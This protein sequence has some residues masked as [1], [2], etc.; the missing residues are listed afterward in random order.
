MK[1]PFVIAEGI[2]GSGKGMI[3]GALKEWAFTKKLKVFDLRGYWKDNDSIPEYEEIKDYDIILSSE[4]T[5]A[6]VGRCI[7]N[8]M[9]KD[10][11]R[12]YS[13]V[14]V[15][16]AFS[17]DREILY[18]KLLIP[19]LKNKKIVFQERGIV[20]SLVYQPTDGIPMQE[21]MNLPGN[22]LALQYLQGLVL[23][24]LV[25]P[26]IALERLKLRAKKDESVYENLTFQKKIDE[27]YRASWLKQLLENQGATVVYLDNNPPKT[28][29]DLM[30]EAVRIWE[31]YYG[32]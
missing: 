10:N 1:L 28:E 16:H 13:A 30:D 23:I 29:Q 9:V 17:L 7:R 24:P 6:L 8:E 11:K 26:E 22:K 12:D 20:S 5:S 19:A 2:D 14:S 21:I 3:I 15:G 32:K 27:R 31:E 4:P 18:R 25:D